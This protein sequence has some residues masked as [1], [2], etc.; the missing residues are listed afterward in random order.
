MK[1]TIDYDV[2]K[3]TISSFAYALGKTIEEII[4]AKTNNLIKENKLLE[5]K[6]LH[7]SEKTVDPNYKEYFGIKSLRNES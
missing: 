6:I 4:E 7:F 2:E 1:I 3:D 5:A